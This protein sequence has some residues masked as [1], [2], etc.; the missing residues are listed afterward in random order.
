MPETSSSYNKSD[1]RRMLELFINL[2]NY[3]P[4]HKLALVDPNQ[5]TFIVCQFIIF[6]YKNIFETFPHTQQIRTLT[7]NVIVRKKRHISLV[8]CV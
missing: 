6:W 4:T 7:F 3:N 5:E 8:P 2:K 1:S